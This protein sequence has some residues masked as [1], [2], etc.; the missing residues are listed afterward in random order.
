MIRFTIIHLRQRLKPAE[1]NL[2]R[3]EPLWWLPILHNDDNY[4]AICYLELL[5]LNQ[6]RFKLLDH[7]QLDF[8]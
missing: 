1:L 8:K 4:E 2:A 3:T 6:H 5:Q 7:P